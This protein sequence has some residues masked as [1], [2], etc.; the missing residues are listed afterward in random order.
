MLLLHI[1]IRKRVSFRF[2]EFAYYLSSSDPIYGT[3]R[4]RT[5]A[6]L[7]YSKER[8]VQTQ[9]RSNLLEDHVATNQSMK[10]KAAKPRRLCEIE[11][12]Y[13]FKETTYAPTYIAYV[14]IFKS[15]P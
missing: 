1:A 10:P 15:G 8:A 2:G 12:I 11:L 5:R 6:R 3:V 13:G 14:D 7:G 4:T 9:V